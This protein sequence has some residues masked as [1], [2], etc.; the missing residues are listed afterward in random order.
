MIVR[1]LKLLQR[2]N[3][4]LCIDVPDSSGAG[5]PVTI[6]FVGTERV[7]TAPGPERPLSTV[8]PGSIVALAPMEAPR[9][10][11][12]GFESFWILLLRGKLM[13]CAV[14][15]GPMNTSSSIC[16]TIP[17]LHVTAL[18]GYTVTLQH[19]V[20]YGYAI[21]NIAVPANPGTR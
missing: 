8:I 10:K 11:S 9:A 13:V 21:A 18:D 1:V 12:R 19:I 16:E 20:F 2:W 7:T 3:V 14:A 6:A 17:K 15:F 4:A 5:L